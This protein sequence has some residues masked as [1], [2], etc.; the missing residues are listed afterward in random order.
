MSARRELDEMNTYLR[1]VEEYVSGSDFDAERHQAQEEFFGQTPPE[2]D[3]EQ[4]LLDQY[5]LYVGWLMF[6]RPPSRT[7]APPVRM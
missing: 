5:G 6:D 3:D 1:Q 4:E 2:F 7:A